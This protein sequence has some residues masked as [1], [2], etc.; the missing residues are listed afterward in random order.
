[1]SAGFAKSKSGPLLNI[2]DCNEVRPAIKLNTSEKRRDTTVRQPPASPVVRVC[3]NDRLG[4]ETLKTSLTA[5]RNR[6]FIAPD[7]LQLAHSN[8]WPRFA[9]WS[10]SVFS[11]GGIVVRGRPSS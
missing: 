3:Q 7:L 6:R 5:H 9:P 8:G 2:F 1:M 4:S 11:S 10:G